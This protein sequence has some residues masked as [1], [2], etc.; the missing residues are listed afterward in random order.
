MVERV[1]TRVVAVDAESPQEEVIR[2]AARVIES[3]GLVAMPTETVYGLG[4]DGLSAEAVARIFE[5]KGRP[6]TNPLILHVASQQQARELSRSWP[7]VAK[8]LC[9]A[10]WPG[11]LTLV[12]RRA[13]QVPDAVT[14][15]L[16]TVAIRMPAH[17]VARA[18]IEAA[19]RPIAAPSANRYTQVSPTTAEHVRAGLDGRVDLILDA[20]PTQVGLESTL[21]SLV[22]DP[23]RILRPGMIGRAELGQVVELASGDGKEG[24]V[25]D[26]DV[27]RMS[28]GL[29][30]RHYSP[31]ARVRVV[32]EATFAQL[33][34]SPR[35][36]GR[37]FIGIGD[38]VSVE[39][40][41]FLP[42]EAEGYARRLYAA[43][44]LVDACDVD[45]IVVEKPPESDE[46][47]AV[48]DRLR[49][50]MG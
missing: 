29:S 19:R 47:E 23:P 21:V 12:V 9:E 34:A 2:E 7:E 25:V 5:A 26:E 17:P 15:G 8:R 40:V 50:A 36:Q 44:H 13:P 18:L 38:E 4:G 11:P 3:G 35:A 28:P 22:E 1:R 6:A 46:W 48:H 37:A 33:I 31:G 20:G 41:V 43:L 10:F 27:P 24:R 14:A 39:G 45:E 30:K 49:R 32:D 16:D 42:D